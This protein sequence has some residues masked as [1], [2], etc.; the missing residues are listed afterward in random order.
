MS[1]VV[2]SVCTLDAFVLVPSSTYSLPSSVGDSSSASVDLSKAI[3]LG[4]VVFRPRSPSVDRIT[5]T[6]L[7]ITPRHRGL[8]FIRI[9]TP[10]LGVPALVLGKLSENE[11]MSGQIL[12]GSIRGVAFNSPK[13]D[14]PDI[15]DRN[16][17]DGRFRWVFVTGDNED[18]C[19]RFESHLR[20]SPLLFRPYLRRRPTE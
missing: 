16:T 19:L 12:T 20:Q 15:G 1:R 4:D 3:K 9:I 18:R 17:G 13:G 8:R 11:F 6:L 7:T 5:M 10:S 14:M 2:R